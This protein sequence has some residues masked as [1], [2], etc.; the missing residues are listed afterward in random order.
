MTTEATLQSI[1]APLAIGGCW[2]MANTS[3]TI[4]YPYAVFYEIV[5]TPDATLNGYSGLVEKRFQIDCFALSYGSAK[6]LAKSITDALSASALVNLKLSEMDGQYNEVTKD[7]QVIT[8][9]SVWSA[10]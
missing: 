1:I 10:D 5:G 8:E 9:F 6:S 4:A 3:S 2:P 7:Y